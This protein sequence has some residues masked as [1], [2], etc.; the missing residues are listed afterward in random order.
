MR[1]YIRICVTHCAHAPITVVIMRFLFVVVV[2]VILHFVLVLN[3]RQ[4]HAGYNVITSR[5]QMKAV[6]VRPTFIIIDII[7]DIAAARN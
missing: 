2:D 5:W 3:N 1:I 6:N 4:Q 7:R